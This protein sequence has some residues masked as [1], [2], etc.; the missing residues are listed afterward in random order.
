ML[1][2]KF[3]MDLKIKFC[4]FL[5]LYSIKNKIINQSQILSYSMWFYSKYPELRNE[6][7][8][9]LSNREQMNRIF[10]MIL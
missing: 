8:R 5:L 1:D 7:F 6:M 3:K 2:I 4:L 9:I 10:E